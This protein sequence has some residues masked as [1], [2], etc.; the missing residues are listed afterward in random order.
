MAG[1]GTNRPVGII[2]AETRPAVKGPGVLEL[3]DVVIIPPSPE[4]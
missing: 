2:L 1:Q 4:G 3:R